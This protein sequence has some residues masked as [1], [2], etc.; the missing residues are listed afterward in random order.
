MTK[1]QK[2][3]FIDL[4]DK[5]I[6]ENSNFYLADISGLSAEESS[7]LR[8]LC[9]KRE[10]SLQVVKNT[11]LKRALEKNASN[12]EELYDV[13]KGNTSI[14]FT[15]VAN[16]PAKVIKEFRKK[17]E[18]PVFKAAHLDASFYIGEEY[19]DT[20]SEL[21]SKNELIAEIVTLLQSPAKNVISSL[22]SGGSKLSGIVKTLAERAE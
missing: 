12:Y 15:D 19:L 16:A 6:Q 20:L 4:L 17:H 13:L 22:Q 5:S 14:M 21:K 2:N 7:N 9:F 1:E 8:R 18:K 10:V 3:Q 11:L